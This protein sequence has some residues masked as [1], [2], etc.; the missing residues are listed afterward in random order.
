MPLSGQ[1]PLSG[2]PCTLRLQ[3]ATLATLLS[4]LATLHLAA[5]DFEKIAPKTP[6]KEEAPTE[7]QDAPAT[8]EGGDEKVL[9]A[10]LKGL[11][12]LSNP[13]AVQKEG[14]GDF[15]GVST[16]GLH[17]ALSPQVE[18]IG[19]KY[20][21]Q[22][23]TIKMLNDLSRE[24][25]ALYRRNDLPVVDVVAPEG[26]DITQGVV[27]V[28]VVEGRV[29]KVTA[30]G[31]KWFE[32]RVLED[33]LRAAKGD[34]ILESTLMADLKWLNNNPF[35]Q[36]SPVVQRGEKPGETD[37]KLKTTDRF[38]LRVYA[39][40]EDTGNDLTGDERFI[41]GM[42]TVNPLFR[43]HLLSY[44]YTCDPHMNKLTAH[45]GS[46]VMP[47]PWRHILTFFGSFAETKG[48]V[49]NP[50]INLNGQS[51]QVSSRYAAPL[52][53]I[54]KFSHEAGFGYDFKS[55]NNN[56]EFG[57][58]NVFNTTTEVSQ[59][60]M[61]YNCRFADDWGQTSFGNSVFLSP[62]RWTPR[63]RDVN[64]IASRGFSSAEY[65]YGRLT[66]ERVTKL[67]WDFTWIAKGMYQWSD[68]N[69]LGSEQLGLGGFSTVRGYGE[70]EVNGDG[71]YLVN[72]E[73]RTP[74]VSVGQLFGIQE[75]M[76]RFQFLGFWDY[77]C[78]QNHRLLVNEDPNLLL[79]SV[80]PGIR[81]TIGPY[82]S[83]RFD[84]GF[85]LYDTAFNTRENSRSH[86]GVIISY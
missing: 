70:R 9:V 22:P 64:F 47:L 21:G 20:L 66:L 58:N 10:S 7:L 2:V 16:R 14:T 37:I 23:V 67:P 13:T 80:G 57:G 17:D 43:D 69:L 73:I 28:L 44:Q 71:G 45:S 12:F 52:P 72:M 50:L 83:V 77:G 34:R 48:D 38:P 40:Y 76:D 53:V 15:Q 19:K 65:T 63:N 74:P 33:Q 41:M 85:Q 18:E 86:V 78:A 32:S 75:A 29:G 3:R 61:T 25:V 30:E 26:Q 8:V 51:W 6:Q 49:A 39:G 24:L 60:V 36:V 11:I 35:R 5:Q 62:G 54:G 55:S 4:I 59:L 84:Y 68:S 81:Y 27:Q 1:I 42:N 82:V 46:Y 31:N 56:L 79:S